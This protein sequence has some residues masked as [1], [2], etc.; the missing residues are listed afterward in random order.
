PVHPPNRCYLEVSMTHLNVLR[1]PTEATRPTKKTAKPARKKVTDFPLWVHQGKQLWTRKIKGKFHYFGRVESE[2]SKQAA[3]KLWLEQRDDLLAGRVPRAKVDGIKLSDVCNSFLSAKRRAVDSGKLSAR[4][5]VEYDRTCQLL[6]K[7]YGR[8]RLAEDLGPADFSKL[9]GQL[10]KSFG[11]TTIGREV[12]KV[13]TLFNFAIESDL[14]TKAIKY[15]PEFVAPSKTDKRKHKAKLKQV[16]GAKTFTA[17]EIHRMLEAAGPQLKAM[18]MLGINCGF[19]NTDCA[20]LP[21]SALDLKNWIDHPRPKTGIDRRVPLWPETVKALKAVIAKRQLPRSPEHAILVF[22][23]RLGQPWVRYELA[24][25]KE[26]D[27]KVKV[28]GKADDAI[29]KATTKLLTNL[30]IKRPG[31]SFY[32]LRHTFETEAGGSRDQVA[33]DAIM[34]HVD[35]SMAAEYREQ[36]D[37]SRLVAVVNHVRKWLLAKTASAKGTKGK[38]VQHGP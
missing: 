14:I 29:A 33:V 25:T 26:D 9:Y 27:G 21:V 13:R 10:V 34:G 11:L 35:A 1:F 5:F 20:S 37:D 18:I 6:I 17:V 4:T 2:A 12:I 3:L 32:A 8:D 28:V 22:L 16:H 31:L 23:T 7:T 36:I 30:G 19:G 38:A 24:E 15:G